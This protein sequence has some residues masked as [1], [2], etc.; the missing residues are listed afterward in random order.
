MRKGVYKD[1]QWLILRSWLPISSQWVEQLEKFLFYQAD[2]ILIL[3][4][5]HQF[6]LVT[7]FV[8]PC[9]SSVFDHQLA[10]SGQD[11]WTWRELATAP[12]VQG[13]CRHTGRSTGHSLCCGLSDTRLWWQLPLGKGRLDGVLVRLWPPESS[14]GSAE[15]SLGSPGGKCCGM[16][17]RGMEWGEG[18]AESGPHPH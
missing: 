10:R 15:M 13:S 9:S 5:G 1:P 16:E 8:G 18:D 14:I 7:G 3:R 6:P 2:E 17:M 11:C 12:R 4:S